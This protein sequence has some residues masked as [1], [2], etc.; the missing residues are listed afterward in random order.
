[1][2]RRQD[3]DGLVVQITGD[4][5]GGPWHTVFIHHDDGGNEIDSAFGTLSARDPLPSL[6]DRTD[7]RDTRAI[8]EELLEW[9]APT[10]TD[11]K[12]REIWENAVLHGTCDLVLD[13]R[14]DVLRGVAWE[15]LGNERCRPFCHTSMGAA[16]MAKWP[17]EPTSPLTSLPVNLLVVIGAIDARVEHAEL[18]A[19]HRALDDRAHDWYIDV[20]RQ[21]TRVEFIEEYKRIKPHILHVLGHGAAG[22]ESGSHTVRIRETDQQTWLFDRDFV[23]NRLRGLTPPR[24]VVLN[25]CHTTSTA[26][27]GPV[28]AL[29]ESG[30]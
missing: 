17:F 21:P 15:L 14:P 4:A 30:C 13:V 25:G 5:D 26:D 7:P 18:E 27:Q 24:L 28:E 1:M 6:D 12:R 23:F 29:L 10:D 9:I 11:D 3:R 22:S 2:G 20:L 16:A 8:G 19:L